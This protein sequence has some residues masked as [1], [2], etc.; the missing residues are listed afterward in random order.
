MKKVV[1][2]NLDIPV[3][4]P[5]IFIGIT[6]WDETPTHK[7]SKSIDRKVSKQSDMKLLIY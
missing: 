4:I 2:L 3:I 1:A 6:A 5:E 7:R